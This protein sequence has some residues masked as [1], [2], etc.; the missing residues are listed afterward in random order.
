VNRAG[1]GPAEI[2]IFEIFLNPDRTVLS[3]FAGGVR[4]GITA[5]IFYAGLEVRLKSRRHL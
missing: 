2:Q 5:N 1:A 4:G 3:L